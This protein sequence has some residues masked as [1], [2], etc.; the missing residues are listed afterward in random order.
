MSRKSTKKRFEPKKEMVIDDPV[1]AEAS[2][3]PEPEPEPEPE[4][5]MTLDEAAIDLGVSGRCALLWF[6]N[7]HLLGT[8]NQGFVRV[9][10]RSIENCRTRFLGGIG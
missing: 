7:G 5:M 3:T 1:K 10:R 4:V 9:S 6:D 2:I 8:N